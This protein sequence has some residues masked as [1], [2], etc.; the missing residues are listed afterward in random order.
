MSRRINLK[1]RIISGIVVAAVLIIAWWFLETPIFGLL[2]AL[3]AA[4]ACFEI[5]KIT[6]VKAKAFKIFCIIFAAFLPL[7]I[8]YGHKI[9]VGIIIMTYVICLFV[10]Y[11]ADYK[12]ITFYDF[13]T[14][15]VASIVIPA[16]FSTL[17]LISDL[18][19][20]YPDITIKHCKYLIW[21]IGSTALFTD[22][23]AYFSG[24]FFG[25]HKMS[26][27]ISP[28]KTIEGAIGGIIIPIGLN[29]LFYYLFSNF[30]FDKTFVLPLY[31]ILILSV[32]ISVGGIM[33][34]LISSLIKRNFSVKDYSN[35]IPGHG[36]IMDR[37][38]SLLF[39]FPVSYII[40]TIFKIYR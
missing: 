21:Y 5:L 20:M 3:L 10:F 12:K 24:Y 26:P 6:G 35:L 38:D 33:G 19:K 8:E 13:A 32:V 28:K 34:D 18:Y 29:I 11:L 9:P 37:F 7:L 22:V 31:F 17:I 15:I 4:G 16:A 25:K 14:S 36:G 40:I 1:V 23:F 39:V 2:M 27:Q 30:Y